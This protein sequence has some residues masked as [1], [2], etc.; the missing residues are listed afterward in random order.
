MIESQHM[1]NN[2]FTLEP[3]DLRDY[4][5]RFLKVEDMHLEDEAASLTDIKR[6]IEELARCLN[7]LNPNMRAAEEVAENT[8]LDEAALERRSFNAG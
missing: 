1:Y 2:S 4:N 3:A 5:K 6:S 8:T 7:Q